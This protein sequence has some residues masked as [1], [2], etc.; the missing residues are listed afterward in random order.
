MMTSRAISVHL[1]ATAEENRLCRQSPYAEFVR[2][3]GIFYGQVV[4]SESLSVRKRFNLDKL[5][6]SIVRPLENVLIWTKSDG[7]IR[8]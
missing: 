4:V 6:N 1:Y 7:T 8:G 2:K 3:K 5:V